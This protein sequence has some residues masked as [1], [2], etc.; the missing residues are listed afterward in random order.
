MAGEDQDQS[1]S[2]KRDKRV[3]AIFTEAL[4]LPA[5]ELAA[6]IRE[7]C[8]EDTELADE[9]GQLLS[10]YTETAAPLSGAPS[11]QG[12]RPLDTDGEERT[13][14]VSIAFTEVIEQPRAA[15]PHVGRAPAPARWCG[16][17]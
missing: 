16:D 12:A 13:R 9:L 10:K 5:S 17:L 1:E 7:Q 15:R 8:G 4:K 2:R 3:R 6:F 11:L 14:R